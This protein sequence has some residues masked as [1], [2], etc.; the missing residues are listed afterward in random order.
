MKESVKIAGTYSRVFLE[1][2][3]KV[4]M[5]ISSLPLLYSVDPV[6]YFLPCYI[7]HCIAFCSKI[8]YILSFINN[9]P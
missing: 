4:G 1:S 2:T 3:D 8:F 9:I 6:N 5:S 7:V